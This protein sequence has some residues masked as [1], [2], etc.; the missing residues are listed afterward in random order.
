MYYQLLQHC[1]KSVSIRSFSDPYFPI[2]GLNKKKIQIQTLLTQLEK[3]AAFLITKWDRYYKV[4]IVL[5]T[6]W[7]NYFKVG[8]YNLPGNRQFL[9]E[10]S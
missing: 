10:N 7:S 8:Q 1:V 4:G 2:F 6:K 3:E 9:P 5:T